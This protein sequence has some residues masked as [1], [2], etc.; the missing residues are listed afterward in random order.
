MIRTPLIAA[1]SVLALMGGSAYAADFAPPPATDWAGLYIGGHAGY[2]FG[3]VDADGAGA[4]I[5]G[6]MGGA[7]GGYNLQSDNLVFGVE[8]DFGFGS[9]DGHDFNSA[10][11]SY[12]LKSNGHLRGRLGVDMDMF[13]PFIAAGLAVGNF[14]V[15]EQGGGNHD[16]RAL[17]GFTAGA[18]VDVRASENLVIRAEYLYDNY[19]SKNFDVYSGVDVGFNT[20]TVRGALIWEFN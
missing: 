17:L 18:G 9:V 1:I 4:D 19:G 13:M 6:F 3:N 14:D 20:H 2:V 12:E 15:E 16:S 5:E 8:A 7:L 10:D 11:L